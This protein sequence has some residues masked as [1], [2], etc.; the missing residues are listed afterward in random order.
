MSADSVTAVEVGID[1]VD[2]VLAL[3]FVCSVGGCLGILFGGVM[4]WL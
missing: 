3:E 4:L 1:I 2:G